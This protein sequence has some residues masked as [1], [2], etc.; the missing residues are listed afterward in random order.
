MSVRTA[1]GPSSLSSNRLH[2]VLRAGIGAR[3]PPP[4]S[5]VYT[6]DGALVG[7]AESS[8]ETPAYVFT[9]PEQLKG[10]RVHPPF[11]VAVTERSGLVEGMTEVLSGVL[12]R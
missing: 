3:A 11:R 5:P 10:V 12:G 9:A 7:Y 1:A 6:S 2:D 8:T 4:P